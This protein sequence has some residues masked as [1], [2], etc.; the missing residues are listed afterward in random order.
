LTRTA[1]W[2]PEGSY[3]LIA[4]FL[5]GCV[6]FALEVIWIHLVGA[7]VG[8]SIYAFSWM[9]TSV[10]IGLWAGAWIANRSQNMRPAKVFLLCAFALLIQL[11]A[12]P[13]APALFAIAPAW[14]SAGF[15][16]RELFRLLVACVLIVPSA[17]SLGLIY[18]TLLK[19][20]QVNGEENAWFAGYLSA[21]N[22]IGC[23][24]GA[25]LS[26]FVLVNR[27]G[28]EL[29]L[30]G[31]TLVLAALWLFFELR[32]LKPG[33]SHRLAAAVIAGMLVCGAI[34]VT[35]NWSYLTSGA[36]MYFGEN[37]P[38]WAASS[39]SPEPRVTDTLVFR[40]ESIQGGFT[41]VKLR[42]TDSGAS[43]QKSSINLFTNGKLQG[44]DDQTGMVQAQ[45]VGTAVLPSLF[46]KH[47]S[48]ALL[49]G[50]GTG[51]G[52][53]VLKQLG[54]ER[55]DIAELSPGIVR[56]VKAEF[57]HTN[58]GVLDDPTVHCVLEDG[59]NLLLTKM[60]TKTDRPYDLI[61]IGL[62]TIWFSGATNLY[63]EE[64]YKLARLHLADDGVLQQWVQLHRIGPAEIASAIASVRSVFPYVSYWSYDGAGMVLAANHP[65]DPKATQRELLASMLSRHGGL[66]AK[67]AEDLMDKILQG[68]LLSEQAVDRMIQKLQPVIN[69]DQNRHLEYAT[70]KY[71]S[72][73]CDW[74]KYNLEFL[75]QWENQGEIQR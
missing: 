35:W 12:W 68:R 58:Q 45:Q 43:L 19:S 36:S 67:D 10:L 38:A 30:K 39:T 24:A 53:A 22:A 18:P 55:L 56:A 44:N 16:T 3:L 9:L 8:G 7:V 59:R 64:F 34:S 17:C 51:H 50:L 47:F 48:N 6:F 21:A 66:A 11:A 71:S 15:Y 74:A 42:R 62:T 29:S 14:I 33:F 28:S 63:S 27:L 73:E 13:L 4:S 57:R 23:L 25:L 41:T 37:P 46:T 75:K 32:E 49:I 20:P 5:S 40:D 65:L 54:F 2:H 69:S 70:P 52:A 26:T 1:K 60:S 61:T 72:A 31:I